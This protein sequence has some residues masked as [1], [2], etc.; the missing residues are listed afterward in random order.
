MPTKKI[1]QKLASARQEFGDA[2]DVRRVF[3]LRESL[4]YHLLK[5]GQVQSA[6]VK[7]RGETR[8][9][10]LYKFS[11]IRRLLEAAVSKE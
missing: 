10:R 2:K 1:P 9:K 7:G 4:L 8:G 11:S 6:L 5:T 3:G